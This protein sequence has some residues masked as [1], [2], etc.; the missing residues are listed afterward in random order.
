RPHDQR[1]LPG[2]QPDRGPPNNHARS[3]LSRL[4]VRP[5]GPGR[6]RGANWASRRP[7]RPQRAATR[8][9]RSV[10]RAV[11][12]VSAGTVPARRPAWLPAL[13]PHGPP[14]GL[15]TVRDLHRAPRRDS[16][17]GRGPAPRLREPARDVLHSGAVSVVQLLRLLDGRRSGVATGPRARAD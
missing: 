17:V 13:P 14:A 7:D 8:L 3:R 2:P 9:G 12:A 16:G 5:P 1:D 10:P 4:A 6:G 11:G 15:A